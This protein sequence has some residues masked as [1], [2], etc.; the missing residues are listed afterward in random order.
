MGLQFEYQWL[1]WWRYGSTEISDKFMFLLS[2]AGGGII[3]EDSDSYY[4][5]TGGN[6]SIVV[7]IETS[8]I[9]VVGF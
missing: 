7:M 3:K 5:I 4:I 2:S 6:R 1:L 8:G 9:W